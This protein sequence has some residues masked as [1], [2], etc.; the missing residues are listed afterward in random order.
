MRQSL[1][2]RIARAEETANARSRFSTECIC[3]PANEPPS[4]NWPVE[5]EIA[6]RVKCPLHGDRFRPERFFVY[7]SQWL[8]EKRPI[9]M[10]THHSEQYRKAWNA[11]FPLNLWPA[12]EILNDAHTI[13]QLKDGTTVSAVWRSAKNE[14]L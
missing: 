9:L 13:L 7:V 11:S 3:F 10:R 2:N 12:Q 14:A 6:A 4:F 5:Q 1:I 8:R